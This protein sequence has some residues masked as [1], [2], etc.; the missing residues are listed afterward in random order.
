MSEAGALVTTR[1]PNHRNLFGV[2]V[3][4]M[5]A[6]GILG[7]NATSAT[8]RATTDGDTYYP[9]VFTFATELYAPKLDID[10]DRRRPQRR[11]VEPGD[12]LQYTL[13]V[14][15]NGQDGATG[16]RLMDSIPTNTTYVPAA[17]R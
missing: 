17:S 14:K 13:A 8:L 12:T 1:D 16:V 10:Q 9:G 11:A 5:D 4:R 6:D 15:N 2:D 7:N 3:D